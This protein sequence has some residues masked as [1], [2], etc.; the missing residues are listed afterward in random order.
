MDTPPHFHRER[1]CGGSWDNAKNMKNNNPAQ[2]YS[3]PEVPLESETGRNDSMDIS[4]K[5]LQFSETEKN[6]SPEK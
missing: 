4:K 6:G 1:A 2:P 5:L 3:N